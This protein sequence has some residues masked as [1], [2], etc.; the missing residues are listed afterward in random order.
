[1]HKLEGLSE[2]TDV[3]SSPLFCR[4]MR[5]L[6]GYIYKTTA[7]EC[8]IMT[9]FCMKFGQLHVSATPEGYWYPWMWTVKWSNPNVQLVM[10]SH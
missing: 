6:S 9:S 4:S 3:A 8:S 5:Y 1:M 10:F 2:S 7:L